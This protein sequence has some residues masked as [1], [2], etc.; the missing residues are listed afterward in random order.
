MGAWDDHGY[1]EAWRAAGSPGAGSNAG[2][3]VPGRYGGWVPANHPDAMPNGPTGPIPFDDPNTPKPT[4][5]P[6]NPTGAIPFDGPAPMPTPKGG[7]VPFDG[8]TPLPTPVGGPVPFDDPNAPK[9]Q[10][11]GGGPI[12]FDGPTP[13]P[14]PGTL[15]GM[16]SPD[17]AG[18]LSKSPAAASDGGNAFGTMGGL[19]GIAASAPTS[20]LTALPQ[21]DTGGTLGAMTRGDRL[22]DQMRRQRGWSGGWG[23]TSQQPTAGNSGM[24][25][26]QAH[27]GGDAR[28]V[29]EEH[30]DR[31][32]ST[33]NF[34]RVDA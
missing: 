5:G 3:F 22:K 16:V 20:S 10:P 23:T 17:A 34:R 31:F 9:P 14:A 24:V 2:A 19:T 12:P 21:V 26:L 1:D 28:P 8:P 13:L 32:L 33:G 6:A 29:P 4:P 7:P 27:E 30:A 25:M 18:D 11:A 15:G